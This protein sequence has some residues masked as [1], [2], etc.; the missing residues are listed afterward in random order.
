MLNFYFYLYNKTDF[1]QRWDYVTLGK[2]EGRLKT[3]KPH[4][5]RRC[6]HAVAVGGAT[7]GT[8]FVSDRRPPSLGGSAPARAVKQNSATAP[9]HNKQIKRVSK[10]N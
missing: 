5:V 6:P 7:V 3:I 10:T 4:T 9:L 2:H 1:L 8:E